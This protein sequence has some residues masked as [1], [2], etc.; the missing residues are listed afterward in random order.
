MKSHTHTQ[1][2]TLRCLPSKLYK[3]PRTLTTYWSHSSL[4]AL[5][6]PTVVFESL[7][8]QYQVVCCVP[9]FSSFELVCLMII[10]AYFTVFTVYGRYTTC[11]F[12]LQEFKLRK[13]II[14]A[15]NL[16]FH[17]T[18]TW[19]IWW[20]MESKHDVVTEHGF[21]R[22]TEGGECILNMG[23][24]YKNEKNTVITSQK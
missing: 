9:P 18:W 22:E 23:L 15:L 6:D 19:F 7:W 13:T 17:V 4:F 5:P 3:G 24:K 10:Y 11:I 1:F 16:V 2:I 21:W 20:I 12:S 14:E 8:Y